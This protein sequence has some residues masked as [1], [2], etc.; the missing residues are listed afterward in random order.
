M[1]AAAAGAVEG[2]G[3]GIQAGA[4]YAAA[5]SQSA[6]AVGSG[7]AS[8]VESGVAG[9]FG[10]GVG[11]AVAPA[12]TEAASAEAPPPS[13]SVAA[14][15]DIARRVDALARDVEEAETA[16]ASGAPLPNQRVVGLCEYLEREMLKLDGVDVADAALDADAVRRARKVQVKKVQALLHR[17]DAVK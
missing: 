9:A 15:A 4:T 13:P 14:I 10:S 7:I 11:V 17:L 6:E 5:I 1:S 2:I 3:A 8:A 16:A 12:R